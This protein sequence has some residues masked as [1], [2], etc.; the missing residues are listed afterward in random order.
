MIFGSQERDTFVQYFIHPIKLLNIGPA[1]CKKN[2]GNII[3]TTLKL[4][5]VVLANS[6][7]EVCGTKKHHQ[8]TK[9]QHMKTILLGD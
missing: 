3:S 6:H 8:Q 4:V 9:K 1:T 5:S 2:L 7:I